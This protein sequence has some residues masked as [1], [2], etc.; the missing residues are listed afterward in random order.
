MSHFSVAKWEKSI[1][2]PPTVTME[3]VIRWL[4][5]DP[6]P[7]GNTLAERL[8]AKRRGLGLSQKKMAGKLGVDQSAY[9]DW[10]RG[11]TIMLK[12]HRSLVARLLAVPAIQVSA[13]MRKRWNDSH[14]R[15]TPI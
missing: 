6:L 15:A 3:R 2:I 12:A 5:Y 11:G 13:A 4:G 10:E 9:S 7:V 8:I 14:G 1:A